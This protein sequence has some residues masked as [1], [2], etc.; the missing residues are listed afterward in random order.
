MS[1]QPLRSQLEALFER[2][3]GGGLRAD[4][5]IDGSSVRMDGN[6]DWVVGMLEGKT[7]HDP[8]YALFGCFPA[9]AGTILDVGANWGYSVGSI[10]ATG[11]KCPILSFEILE[12]YRRCLE[13]VKQAL[14]KDYDYI[15]S[16]VSDHHSELTLQM[17]TLNGLALTALATARS[18]FFGESMIRNVVDYSTTY[19]GQEEEL[20]PQ[21]CRLKVIAAPID[22]LVLN[23]Q[24][25]VPTSSIAAVKIDIEGLEGEALLGA[26]N[27]LRRDLPM[28]LI[29]SGTRNE[30]V[31]TQLNVH[32]YLPAKRNGN[33]LYVVD[34]SATVGSNGIF[35]H[36]GRAAIYRDWGL[37]V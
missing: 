33:Q 16:G 13:A 11:C 1:I 14:E 26:T 3:C 2:A 19:M 20:K 4:D 10:R 6:P 37:L 25:Q 9:E 34:E 28:L 27:I 29:E 5:L 36:P 31:R 17:P 35:V 12:P 21:I 32:G 18:D 24:I 15:I 22:F 8:D 23:S 7:L 30:K